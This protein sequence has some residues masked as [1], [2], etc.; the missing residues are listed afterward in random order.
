LRARADRAFW[1]RSS[2]TAPKL[3]NRQRREVDSA[4]DLTDVGRVREID[5]ED[6]LHRRRPAV[7]LPLDVALVEKELMV[8]PSSMFDW[9]CGQPTNVS[10]RNRDVSMM[11]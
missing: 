3:R 7:S 8:V 6:L 11:R 5:L 4:R 9:P 10:L 2:P 1:L